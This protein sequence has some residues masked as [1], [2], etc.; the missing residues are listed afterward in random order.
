MGSQN[1]Q[2]W[3]QG[4]LTRWIMTKT[5]LKPSSPDSSSWPGPSWSLPWPGCSQNRAKSVW[6]G[7]TGPSYLIQFL[8]PPS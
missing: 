6:Q 5:K 2:I 3:E 4:Q 8:I 1:E 7:S